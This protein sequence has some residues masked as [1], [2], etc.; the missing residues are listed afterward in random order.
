MPVPT[1]SPPMT[2][3]D[4]ERALAEHR[5]VSLEAN[6]RGWQA[7]DSSQVAVFT[8]EVELQLRARWDSSST[9]QRDCLTKEPRFENGHART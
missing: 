2:A 5:I 7:E 8:A 4:H 9:P 1:T 6:R 3:T